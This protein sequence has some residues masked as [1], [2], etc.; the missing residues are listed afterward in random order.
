[1]FDRS[2]QQFLAITVASTASAIVMW[3]LLT[4]RKKYGM[5]GMR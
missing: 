2:D 4:G 3:W 5:K 1:M